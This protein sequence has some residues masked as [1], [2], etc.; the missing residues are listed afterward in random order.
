MSNIGEKIK[1]LRTE[2]G[3]TQ[4]Q[5][6][7]YAGCSGQVIS[8][9]ERGYTNP[10]AQVLNKIAEFFHVPSDYL[11]G[12][13]KSQWIALNPE[14][15]MPC[16]G[17]RI[18]DLMQDANMSPEDLANRVEISIQTTSEILSGAITPNIDVLAKISKAL[19]TSIDFLIGAVPFQ[20]IIS[21]EEEQDIILYYRGMSKSGKRMIM[22]D[23]EKLKGIYNVL[24]RGTVEVLYS[25]RTKERRLVLMVTYSDLFTFVIM[26]CAVIT[27]V[28]TIMKHKK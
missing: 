14:T 20:T 26:L 17:S 12:K 18:S 9:I 1:E 28:V 8:N 10:S 21:S 6:G 27:L 15:R 5:L 23:F 24:N 19:N 3:A 11:L 25:R 22:G 13:S 7:E 16:I 2:S 4:L